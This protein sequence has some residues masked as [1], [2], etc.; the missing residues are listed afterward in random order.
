MT[1]LTIAGGIYHERA[2]WPSWDQIFGSA[3]RAA[4]ALSGH[5]G[6]VTLYSYARPD[7][8][9]AFRPYADGYGFTFKPITSEQTISF[10]YVHSLAPPSVTP[11][12]QRIRQNHPFEVCDD[13]VLRFGMMEGSAIIQA[14]RCVYDPQSPVNPEPFA[15]N[16]SRAQALAIVA[17]RTEVSALAGTSDT[18]EAARKLCSA[19]AILVAV[20]SGPEGVLIV[21]DS[22]ESHVPAYRTERVWTVGSGDVFAAHFAARWAAH[23][24]DPVYAAD[25]ASRAVADYVECMALP[26]PSITSLL[27]ANRHP[28]KI[29]SGRVYLASPFFTLSQRWLVDE[30]RRALRELGLDVFSPVH[31]VGPGPARLVAPADLAA[32]DSCDAVFAIFDGLDSGT[33]FEVGYARALKKPVYALAQTVSDED[34]KMVVGSDCR[35]FDDFVT[36]I[37]HTA[38]RT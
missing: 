14:N 12:V 35:V 19:G 7:T 31:D 20:K 4:T 17:N 1:T 22:S 34:L 30:T 33:V 5:V 29:E 36:A 32:L 37:Y 6:T 26:S 16:G 25:I 27:E 8:A 13:N 10:E 3:G 23:G 21:T 11:S 2:I 9:E 18:L 38:W 24:D 15:A 28:V